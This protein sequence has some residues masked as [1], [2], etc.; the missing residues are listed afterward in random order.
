MVALLAPPSVTSRRSAYG[1]QRTGPD[2]KLAGWFTASRSVEYDLHRNSGPA[3]G[4]RHILR[5][6][7]SATPQQPATN[8]RLQSGHR[9]PYRL[10]AI[11]P[12]PRRVHF[13]GRTA[14]W[15]LITSSGCAANI[16]LDIGGDRW[17]ALRRRSTPPRA[18]APTWWQT[19]RQDHRNARNTTAVL[20][21]GQTEHGGRRDLGRMR[22]PDR[23]C[24][25][26]DP[27]D[28]LAGVSPTKGNEG[29][30]LRRWLESTRTPAQRQRTSTQTSS[31]KLAISS[32]TPQ[33][34]S[35]AERRSLIECVADLVVHGVAAA[36]D[37]LAAR[38]M[39][40]APDQ[41]LCWSG[42]VSAPGG[43]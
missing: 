40:T 22:M 24:G 7:P 16:A 33:P 30:D 28:P 6:S 21:S 27:R 8:P 18:R 5:R 9:P 1:P 10:L 4:T 29:D 23:R 43:G 11:P 2:H 25:R 31:P 19:H 32:S 36:A 35:A 42:A 39:T 12:A 15:A 37:E 13:S 38:Q 34:R 3:V 14:T 20:W 26:F 17:S 41:H